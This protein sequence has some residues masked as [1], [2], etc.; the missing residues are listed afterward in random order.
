MG[1]R[2]EH[3][4]LDLTIQEKNQVKNMDVYPAPFI[5][6]I[7]LLWKGIRMYDISCPP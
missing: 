3:L 4:K 7:Q 5:N 2:N 1:V 6:E